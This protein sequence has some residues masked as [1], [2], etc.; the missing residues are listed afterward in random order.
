V[1]GHPDNLCVS[2]S[3][4]SLAMPHNTNAGSARVGFLLSDMYPHFGDAGPT[5]FQVLASAAFVRRCEVHEP[6]LHT[7]V[8][9]FE[10]NYRE[11]SEDFHKR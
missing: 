5:R 11:Y 1:P 3:I 7:D 4:P 2:G 8:A 10:G 9:Y 6:E